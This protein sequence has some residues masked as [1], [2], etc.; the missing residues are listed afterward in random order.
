M[1]R[2]FNFLFTRDGIEGHDLKEVDSKSK[3]ALKSI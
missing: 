1:Q 3:D 2:K